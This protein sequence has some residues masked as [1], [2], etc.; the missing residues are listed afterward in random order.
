M[1][2]LICHNP[3]LDCLPPLSFGFSESELPPDSASAIAAASG[4]SAFGPPAPIHNDSN[5]AYE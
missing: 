3:K 2:L 1:P 5:C 4:A